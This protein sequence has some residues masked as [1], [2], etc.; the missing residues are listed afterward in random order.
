MYGYAP[1]NLTT[2]LNDHSVNPHFLYETVA[3]PRILAIAPCPQYSQ[4]RG[5]ALSNEYMCQSCRSSEIIN[6]EK[7][8]AALSSRGSTH[9]SLSKASK[10]LNEVI[11]R[12]KKDVEQLTKE[13]VSLC[14]IE[15]SC[16][17]SNDNVA[18]VTRIHHLTCK[19][20]SSL[21]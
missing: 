17:M 9:A 6:V 7:Q 1:S 20:S 11:S 4:Q 19:L 10:Q 5:V 14:K 13:R 8:P 2:S 21:S 18:L 3:S 12:H 15:P 16:V